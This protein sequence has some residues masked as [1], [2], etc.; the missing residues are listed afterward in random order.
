MSK[1]V[2]KRVRIRDGIAD[3]LVELLRERLEGNYDVGITVSPK[4]PG[5]H[6]KARVNESVVEKIMWPRSIRQDVEDL[7][8]ELVALRQRR[9]R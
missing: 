1:R 2:S 6:V 8:G 4:G 9:Y 5:I 3:R 7:A